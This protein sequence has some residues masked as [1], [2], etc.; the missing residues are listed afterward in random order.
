M[1]GHTMNKNELYS[2]IKHLRQQNKHLRK[3]LAKLSDKQSLLTQESWQHSLDI[4]IR[5]L[6]V[7]KT[8]EIQALLKTKE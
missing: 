6:Q 5:L 8:T 3:K 4:V 2:Q 1:K 7:A